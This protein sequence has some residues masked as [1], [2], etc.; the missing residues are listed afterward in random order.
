MSQTVEIDLDRPRTLRFTLGGLR[1]LQQRLAGATLIEIANRIGQVDAEAIV[2]AL[3]VGLSADDKRLTVDQ[4]QNLI[5]RKIASGTRMHELIRPLVD[6]IMD[7]AGLSPAPSSGNGD[8][9][10]EGNA[11]T[12]PSAT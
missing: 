5:D 10:A 7:G 9:G 8:G 12:G 11:P 1:L 3:W 6:A 4:A 2:H